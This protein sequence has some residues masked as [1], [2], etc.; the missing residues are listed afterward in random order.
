MYSSHL[1]PPTAC[2]PRRILH[3]ARRLTVASML[4]T[5]AAYAAL[6]RVVKCQRV[7]GRLNT[8]VRR[9]PV[10]PLPSLNPR[11]QQELLDAATAALSGVVP[12][13][14]LAQAWPAPG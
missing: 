12:T 14:Q 2:L 5:R 9:V 6:P 1:R 3:H 11:Q 4:A 8:A 13:E 7:P 10:S